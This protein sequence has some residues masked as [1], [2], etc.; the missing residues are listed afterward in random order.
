[1]VLRQLPQKHLWYVQRRRHGDEVEL[2][3]PHNGNI[4]P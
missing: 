4:D 2:P 1:M 3:I